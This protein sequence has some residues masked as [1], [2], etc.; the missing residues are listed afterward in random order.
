MLS[1]LKVLIWYNRIYLFKLHCCRDPVCN[2]GCYSVLVTVKW[3]ACWI[4]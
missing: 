3:I 1:E 2:G 4:C